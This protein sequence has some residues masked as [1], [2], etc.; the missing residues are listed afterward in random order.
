M[1]SIMAGLLALLVLICTTDANPSQ[2]CPPSC[3]CYDS[4]NLV[5]CR[6][7]ELLVVPHHLPH[8]TWMLDLR[9]NNLSRLEPTSFQALWSLRILLLSDNQ[10]EVVLARSL[11]SL[12]FLER[13]DLSNNFLSNLPHDFSRGLG[14]LRELRVPANRL[15][16]LTYESLRHMESLEK[17]DLSRN[18]L[19]YIEQGAF[20]GLSR[21]RHLHLQSNLLDSVRGGYFFMLQNLELL[22]LSDNNISSIAVESFTSLHSLRLLSLSDNQL[23]H[24]KFKTFLNLQTPSTHI[25]VSGNPWIC[26]CD[27]QRVFGKITSVRHLHIDDYDNLT[28][29]GPPQLSGAALVSV[30]NQLCV[31]ET[32]TVLVITITVLVTV[33]AAIV[34]AER[35]RKK[36][37]E[38]NWN[39]PDGPF[40]TQ[41][42]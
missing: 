37:Q 36:N 32:A 25:Q 24:L 29:A 6:G 4:S 16:A 38:K 15:T 5:E 28:C 42:K 41:D 8:S 19:N 3:L 35:N 40:E 31:A 22:D 14:S 33:I 9:H 26:D 27:L 17:L 23:S 2:F 10:I 1:C 34:M 39:E 30:D 21:L 12:G 11:R 20:R 18:Y 7:L 13:L